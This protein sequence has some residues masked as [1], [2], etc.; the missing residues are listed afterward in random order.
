MTDPQSPHDAKPIDQVAAELLAL[1]Q[2]AG[3]VTGIS[4]GTDTGTGL[5]QLLSGSNVTITKHPT[6][7]NAFVI[8][9]T[10]GGGGGNVDS[11]NGLVGALQ[12]LAGPGVNVSAS[13]T[14]ITISVPNNNLAATYVSM[15]WDYNVQGMNASYNNGVN[16]VGAFLTANINGAIPDVDGIVPASGNRIAVINLI[17]NEA[18]NGIYIITDLGSATTPWVMTRASDFDTV[19]TMLPGTTFTVQEG[20]N[21]GGCQVVFSGINPP[22]IGTGSIEFNVIPALSNDLV[23]NQIMKLDSKFLDTGTNAEQIVQLGEGGTLPAVPAD[24]VSVN[25]PVTSTR[26]SLGITLANIFNAISGSSAALP[27]A[28]IY[29]EISENYT[30]P[31]PI[32]YVAEIAGDTNNLKVLLPPMN[33]NPAPLDVGQSFIMANLHLQNGL[34]L[35]YNDGTQAANMEPLQAYIVT[36]QDTSTS[37]GL[38][39]AIPFFSFIISPTKGNLFGII[40]LDGDDIS[41]GEVN[42]FWKDTTIVPVIQGGTGA[43]TAQGALNTLAG[44]VASGQVLAGNNT[45][46]VM[47]SISSV[48][49]TIGASVGSLLYRGSSG[50]ALLDA[51][52][53]GQFLT[54]GGQGVSPSWTADPNIVQ[55]FT[56]T[57]TPLDPTINLVEALGR[58]FKDGNRISLYWVVVVP[59]N[60][61]SNFFQIDGWD[62]SIAPT[63]QYWNGDAITIGS[64]NPLNSNPNQSLVLVDRIGMLFNGIASLFSDLNNSLTVSGHI[65]WFVDTLQSNE[66]DAK[67]KRGEIP[68]DINMQTAF[69]A[70]MKQIQKQLMGTK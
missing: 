61:S 22:S 34:Q 6:I 45:D 31:S 68:N 53:Q 23:N 35:C 18:W 62:A 60:S 32:P 9:A 41:D 56:W 51:G 39:S 33:T 52:D 28:S 58:G 29:Q 14:G 64:T 37:N 21:Y 11:L 25:N 57:P 4:D 40:Q 10:G 38:I 27:G 59:G 66:F 20:S 15:I 12:I 42:K 47:R 3:G 55:E 36:I 1:I 7:A 26:T 2:A 17:N 49:D 5:V 46:V 13:G 44:G 67:V 69:D 8:A 48:L 65:D 43:T 70:K 54:S 19:D 30:L 50:W 24:D 16:G 63:N